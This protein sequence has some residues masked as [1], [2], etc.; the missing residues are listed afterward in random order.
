M[1]LVLGLSDFVPYCLL[2]PLFKSIPHPS[3]Y[4]NFL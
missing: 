3:T 1:L 2:V 4:S